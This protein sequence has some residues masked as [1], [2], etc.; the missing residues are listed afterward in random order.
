M[1]TRGQVCAWIA[2]VCV[3]VPS[4]TTAQ[5][6]TERDLIELIVRDG[7]QARALRA[8]VEVRRREQQ[9][10]WAYPNPSVTYS[11]E[12]AGF[13]EFL[14]AEQSLPI[15][16]TRDRLARAGVA[17]TA[18]AEAERDARLWLL[19][20]HAAA[21][22]SRVVAEQT[23]L[24]AARTYMRE[25]ERLIEI[26]RTR[27]R[28]GEGSRFDRLRAQEEFREGNQLVTRATVALA[29]ARAVLAGMLPQ[30]VTLGGITPAAAVPQPSA[31]IDTLVTRATS[32]HPELRA[33]QHT[34][35]Q[36]V[37]E[38]EASRRSRLPAPTVF[39]GLKRA[40]DGAGRERGGVFGISAAI[41]LFD[42]GGREAARWEAERARVDAERASVQQRIRG[43]IAGAVEVLSARQAALA[44]EG[45]D[46]AGELV[47]IAEVA[48]REGE[49]GILELLDAVRT[50]ARAR[51]RFIDLR[52]D[53]RLA[54]IA[55]ERAV[56]E[57]LWP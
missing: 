19:R 41:P 18:A 30:D 39:G 20:T 13:T 9:A 42:N 32:T 35:E 46:G 29:E 21:A 49:V 47:Q 14:Q 31:T 43:E 11:R 34:S 22:V 8:D 12:G 10:R 16:G 25:L 50:A 51:D 55:L 2:V 3:L 36:A 44:M 57:T 40:G 17:A 26:L 1:S 6:R 53:V 27:E 52:L 33:L 28:E 48:Y 23:R 37:L 4:V 45:Q 5:D 24:D 7:P 56:G 15:F 38:A 54:Q